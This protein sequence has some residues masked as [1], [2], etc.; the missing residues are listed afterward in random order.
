[1]PEKSFPGKAGG[2]NEK[3]KTKEKSNLLQLK[4]DREKT[5][6]SCLPSNFFFC[7]VA[8]PFFFMLFF[9]LQSR[10]LT[11][12]YASD[13]EVVHVCPLIRP[14]LKPSVRSPGPSVCPQF[15]FS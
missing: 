12:D 15:L 3:K 11:K 14:F 13:Q 2:R 7:S 6:A 4:S 5:L 10:V 1:M 9:F 8:F